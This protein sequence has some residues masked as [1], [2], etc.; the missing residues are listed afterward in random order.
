MEILPTVVQECQNECNI[1]APKGMKNTPVSATE[2]PSPFP[3]PR[4]YTMDFYILQIELTIHS[5]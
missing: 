1:F 5:K 2:V 3:S 4:G